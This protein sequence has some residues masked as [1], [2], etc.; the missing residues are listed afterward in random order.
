MGGPNAHRSLEEG[1]VCPVYLVDL[2]FKVNPEFQG[3]FF[4]DQKV[5]EF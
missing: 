1:V 2:P 5:L 3:K 4:L